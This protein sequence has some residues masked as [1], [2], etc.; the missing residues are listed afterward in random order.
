MTLHRC[1]WTAKGWIPNWWHTVLPAGTALFQALWCPVKLA[2]TLPPGEEL[3]QCWLGEEIKVFA[4]CPLRKQESL[5][6]RLWEDF[7][8]HSS[9]REE[10]REKTHPFLS[11]AGGCLHTQAGIVGYS[12]MVWVYPTSHPCR[13]SLS[14]RG[15]WHILQCKGL[16]GRWSEKSGWGRLSAAP[17]GTANDKVPLWLAKRGWCL[18][19]TFS[20]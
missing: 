11:Q 7:T 1:H 3:P 8:F 2:S 5:S 13:E 10:E 6:L 9:W 15:K 17:F 18:Q 19:S 20:V 16:G 4:L 14:S 12:T